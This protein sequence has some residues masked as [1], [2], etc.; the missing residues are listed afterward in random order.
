M[1]KSELDIYLE[2][3]VIIPNPIDPL[4]NALQWWKEHK[5]KYCILSKMDCHILSIPITSVASESAFSAGSRVI[6]P[7]RASL[8]TDIVQMLICGT[9]WIRSRYGVKATEKV[10]KFEIY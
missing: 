6:D 9:D 2:D 8:N 1:G 5:N 10:S 3:G 4:F 7:H